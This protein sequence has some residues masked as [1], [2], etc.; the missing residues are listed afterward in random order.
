MRLGGRGQLAT[1]GR[2]GHGRALLH[3]RRGRRRGAHALTRNAVQ[4]HPVPDGVPAH[5]EEQRGAHDVAARPGERLADLGGSAGGRLA[6]SRG[7]PCRARDGRRARIAGG[8]PCRR[9]AARRRVSS[10]RAG[11]R[12]QPRERPGIHR[13]RGVEQRHALHQVPQLADVARPALPPQPVLGVGG[14]AFRPRAVAL[15][16]AP[17]HGAGQRDNVVAALPERREPEHH[18]GEAVVQVRPEPPRRGQVGEVVLGRGEELH[19]H[20]A[21]GDGAEAADAL[22]L[23]RGEQLALERRGRGSRSRPGRACRRAA[24]SKRPG[25]ARRAS[26]NAPGS[27]PKT[28][29]SSMVAGIAAQFTGT[30]GPRARGPLSWT[31]RATSPLP[32]PVSPWRSSVGTLPPPTAS[33]PERW[34]IWALS[35]W[36]AGA[37]PSNRSPGCPAAVSCMVLSPGSG[38]AR[39][40]RASKHDAPAT[41]LGGP[42]RLFKSGPWSPA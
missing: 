34:L 16:Q 23:D 19:V 4:A 2:H 9:L 18:H 8:W 36:I 26:V 13:G 14:E 35:A 11:R 33:N 41:L 39:Y 10:V 30:N 6:R 20:R 40:E 31:I 3:G 22:V 24:A 28:S 1:S 32:V 21:L 29:A 15:G 42:S 17:E 5:A 25:R 37:V 12:G 7:V 27:W 38:S